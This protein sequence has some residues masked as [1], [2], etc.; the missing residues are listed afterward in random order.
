MTI[1]EI[2]AKI[3][4]LKAVEVQSKKAVNFLM[5][6]EYMLRALVTHNDANKEI[7]ATGSFDTV[8]ADLKTLAVE[9]WGVLKAPIKQIEDDPRYKAFV[10]SL[11]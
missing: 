4:A 9:V 10:E 1:E 7:V 2:Q 11:K 6:L 5:N 8:D 3:A